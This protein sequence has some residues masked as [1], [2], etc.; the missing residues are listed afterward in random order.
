MTD[1][2][3]YRGNCHC[4]KYR[5]EVDLPEIKSATSCNCVACFKN[6]ILWAFPSEG[7]FRI[8]RDDGLLTSSSHG[9]TL[10]Q[11]FCSACAC[12]VTGIHSSGPFQGIFGINIRS[13]LNVNPFSLQMEQSNH[14][15]A[16]PPAPETVQSSVDAAGTKTYAGSCTCGAI[17]VGFKTKPLPEVQVK[18]DNCSLCVRKAYIGVYPQ[19][20]QVTV[21]GTENTSVYAW[22][23]KFGGNRFCKFCGVGIWGDLYGPPREV[24][25]TWPEARQKMVER[26]LQLQP[27]NVRALEEVEWDR[28]NIERSDEGTEG[29]VVD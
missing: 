20:S 16:E 12:L 13:L 19:K 4:A 10:D 9:G 14:P 11:K 6:G 21:T 24:V 3:T 17:S 22:G 29:Y 1:K 7:D 23:Q 27:L 8:T 26:K 15:A 28:I 5:F 25:A 18:E 2:V